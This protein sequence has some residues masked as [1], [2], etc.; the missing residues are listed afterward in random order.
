MRSL[1]AL[2][3]TLFYTTV[4]SVIKLVSAWLAL[5]LIGICRSSRLPRHGAAAVHRST[6]LS[7][8]AFW[9][10]YDSQFSIIGRSCA[11]DSSPT[12]T[13][14]RS[15]NA[16]AT[17]AGTSGG[18]AVRA[19]TLL[20]PAND[21]AFLLRSSEPDGASPWQQFAMTLLPR[22]SSR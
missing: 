18:R 20:R 16:F 12:S 13:S 2:F 17:I 11:W 15:V 9:W 10:I 3:N 4:A 8:I 21:I 1:S 19:I 22:R 7:A 5:L 6:A 14:G